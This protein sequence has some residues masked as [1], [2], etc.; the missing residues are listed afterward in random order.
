MMKKPVPA[1]R[2]PAGLTLVEVLFASMFMSF[3]ALMVYLVLHRSSDTYSNESMHLALDERAREAMSE[4]A[5][6]LRE[7]GD[8]TLSTGDPP[9]PVLDGQKVSDLRFGVHSGYDMTGRKVLYTRVVRYRFMPAAGEGYVERTDRSGVTT[10]L[11]D[12][13]KNGGLT[14]VVS[15][16]KVTVTLALERRDLKGTLI[17]REATTSVELRN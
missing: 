4:I 2:F 7:A 5:R 8:T 6:D 1:K 12:D 11:C 15:G 3:M 14:F 10:H 13:V 16:R 9:L 17:H